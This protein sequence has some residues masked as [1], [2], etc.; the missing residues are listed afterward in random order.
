MFHNHNQ[1]Q[2]VF[3]V[4]FKVFGVIGINFN[5]PKVF[6]IALDISHFIDQKLYQ[7]YQNYKSQGQH[8]HAQIYFFQKN[9][10]YF[11]NAESY[12]C[13]SYLI[14]FKTVF[15]CMQQIKVLFTFFYTHMRDD[16]SSYRIFRTKFQYKKYKNNSLLLLSHCMEG[17]KVYCN[18]Q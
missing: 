15:A 9:A 12:I 4:S 7:S 6:D 18:S 10:H 5:A 13:I 2:L 1:R 3:V 8:S 11:S 17:E 14:L 16:M